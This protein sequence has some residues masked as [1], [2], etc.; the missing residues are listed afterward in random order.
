MKNLK[1]S[2]KITLGFGLLVLIVLLMGGMAVYNMKQAEYASNVLDTQNLDELDLVSHLER[3]VQQLMYNMR[4]YAMR[5]DKIYLEAAEKDEPEI[6][7]SL[8]KGKE[9]V[10]MMPFLARLR[11][12]VEKGTGIMG[13][14]EGLTR[15]LVS[16]NEAIEQ[17]RNALDEGARKFM[18]EA[19]GFLDIETKAMLADIEASSDADKLREPVKKVVIINDITD[20][21]NA[22]RVATQKAQA[23]NDIKIAR[24][25]MKHFETIMQKLEQLKPMVHRAE[26]VRQLEEIKGGVEQ[27]HKAMA[28][29]LANW[30]TREEVAS[31]ETAAGNRLLELT[32]DSS[33]QSMAEANTHAGQNT[34]RLSNSATITIVGLCVAMALGAV[35][36]F[37]ITRSITKPINAAIE[38][39]AE[40]SQ[41][42]AS[43][44]NQ[45]S[46]S[47]QQLA[48]GAAEQA[49]ALE[50]TSSSLEEMASMTKTNADNAQQANDLAQ[51]AG[52]VVAKA[53]QAMAELTKAMAE[54]NQ[55]GEE[56]GKIIKTIDEIAFQT[57]LLA[58]NAAVEA[59]RAGEAGAGF[60]VVAEEVRN[61]AMR[62]AEAAK[63]TANLIESTIKKTKEGSELVEKTNE[64]FSEVASTAAK[65]G[66]L[67]GEIAAA[68]AEQAQGIDQVNKAA[69]EMDKV[70]QSNAANAEES[71]AAAEEL[72]AQAETMNG[73]VEDLVRLVGNSERRGEGHGVFR[74][75]ERPSASEPRAL[76]APGLGSTLGRSLQ[77]VKAKAG[78][79]PERVVPMDDDFR[80]F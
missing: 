74:H 5:G 67:V 7:K 12:L 16:S 29:L 55:A 60:A 50:E 69:T 64:A 49:A 56:T 66:E 9:M 54:V 31:K 24:E 30:Q 27:Y 13:E 61:L 38:G 21:G 10:Q 78:T 53:N 52:R 68:S 3:R 32:L 51:E 6:D 44:A 18:A 71:A 59:A 58:L 15:Q 35:L 25:G 80:E 42:V 28:G 1:L 17:S 37:F 46:T 79:H 36:A 11:G 62:A 48:E 77:P 39:L 47:G 26:N 33:R 2:A 40:G 22:L 34:A 8:E 70:T 72:T 43:A 23:N 73:F 14:F 41:Q 57:N 4:G 20:A 65:V 75:G 76:P 45:V 63:N 19:N